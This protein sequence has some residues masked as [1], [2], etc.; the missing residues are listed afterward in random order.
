MT[1]V[2]VLLFLSLSSYGE[3]AKLVFSLKK[4][5]EYNEFKTKAVF[6]LLDNGKYSFKTSTGGFHLCTG[7]PSGSFKGKLNKKE[8]ETLVKQFEEMDKVCSK[9][10]S[11]SNKKNNENKNSFDWSLLGWGD[12][13]NKQY[14]FKG[15][16]KR[17]K[18]FTKI[19]ELEK[20]LYSNPETSLTIKKES[21]KNNKLRLSVKYLGKDHF[22]FIKDDSS[23]IV[24]GSKKQRRLNPGQYIV[25]KLHSGETTFYTIDTK[26]HKLRKSDYLIY[27]PPSKEGINA[28]IVI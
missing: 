15:S 1:K 24:L 7:S 16:A 26:I 3:Q 11:C 10:K 5:V 12:Y 6:T 17:P 22:E 18:L 9:L 21:H 27:S 19:F 4:V 20:T 8:L 14:F 13:S 23:F 25:K 28:C 2:I